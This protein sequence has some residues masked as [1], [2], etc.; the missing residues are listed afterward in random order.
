MEISSPAQAAGG[1]SDAILD[2]RGL[3]LSY[4]AKEALQDISIRIP[5]KTVTAFIGPSGCGK[6]TLLR[7]LNRM[8][9]LVDNVR[10]RGTILLDGMDILAPSVDVIELRRRVGMVFQA[11]NPFPKSVYE[12]V[13]SAC[14]LPG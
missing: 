12:N 6:S 1:I 2:I 3:H 14:G 4:G 13:I 7:S 9:D 11:P 5:R 8:N 10:T